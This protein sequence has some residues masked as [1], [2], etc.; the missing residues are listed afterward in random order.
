MKRSTKFKCCGITSVVIGVILLGVGIGWPF[1]IDSLVV[2]QSKDQAALGPDNMD[3][4]KGIPGKFDIQLNR[5]TYLY[6]VVNRDD[7]IFNGAVPQVE[8]YGPFIYREYDDYSTPEVWDQE[9]PIPGADGK[10][11]KAIRMLFN[12]TAKYNTAKGFVEYQDPDIDTQIWQINQAALGLWFAATQPPPFR[13]ALN[14]LYSVVTD[15]LGRQVVQTAGWTAMF[16]LA[17]TTSGIKTDLFPG[18]GITDAQATAMLTDPY[19]GLNN[20]NNYIR[21]DPLT[22]GQDPLQYQLLFNE[23][24]Y[25]FGLTTEQI[26]ICTKQWNF[27]TDK[28][29][30]GVKAAVFSRNNDEQGVAYCQ[31]ANSIVT[32]NIS[33]PRL[34]SVTQQVDTA[35]GWPEIGFFKIALFNPTIL[36]NVDLFK[37]FE[38][39]KLYTGFTP[40]QI[41]LNPEYLFD[42]T[43]GKGGDPLPNSLFNIDTLQQLLDLGSQAIDVI[44]KPDTAA[45]F[46]LDVLKPVA[47]LLGLT[48]EQTYLVYMWL[49][50]VKR[51][52]FQRETEG[53]STKLGILS[54]L[55]SQGMAQMISTM[56][57]EIPLI[58]YTQQ[59]WATI[60]LTPGC[61][62]F[63][64][65]TFG[66][67]QPMSDALCSGGILEVDT[68][69]FK[70]PESTC[71]A[72]V[73]IML[74]NNTATPSN[75]ADL[76]F[77]SGQSA[78]QLDEIM[79]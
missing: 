7:V 25:R 66:F 54:Q 75:Y 11:A 23:L 14:L 45:D 63:Y 67:P 65:K 27:F 33:T 70:D 18:A 37:R 79:F 51:D 72:W 5:N 12:Q 48:N 71:R 13:L 38:N 43:D 31:W 32:G 55:T 30:K 24:R 19:F 77:L 17:S 39:V 8:E 62:T 10:T 53:G 44:D 74:N 73:N 61:N 15:G 68:Y 35:T 41:K 36:K 56:E 34:D 47:D 9:V 64:H 60:D 69:S 59:L 16:A 22:Y 46:S 78:A 57:Q 49:K 29:K 1:I 28:G 58:L 52:T 42:M 2:S 4:W 3:Q 21:W 76:V 50:Y 26:N 20:L 6:N 40:D